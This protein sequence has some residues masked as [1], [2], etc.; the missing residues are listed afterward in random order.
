MSCDVADGEIEELECTDAGLSPIQPD[1]MP[2]QD[3]DTAQFTDAGT[4]P[5]E[6]LGSSHISQVDTSEAATLTDQIDTKDS[7]CS[8]IKPEESPISVT[9]KMRDEEILQRR[10]GSGD[11]KA[12]I[13]MLEEQAGK[14]PQ[15][16]RKKKEIVD[17]EDEMSSM[18]E[19]EVCRGST[20]TLAQLDDDEYRMES[21]VEHIV[22]ERVE[23]AIT[24]LNEKPKPV[25][26]THAKHVGRKIAE[27]QKIFSNEDV[28]TDEDS[29]TRSPIRLRHKHADEFASLP[30]HI[31]ETNRADEKIAAKFAENIV[32][33]ELLKVAGEFNRDT[34][35]RGTSEPTS[36]PTVAD[37]EVFKS[38]KDKTSMFEEL[39]SKSQESTPKKTKPHLKTTEE[40]RKPTK[41][42]ED[43]TAYLEAM[44]KNDK[45]SEIQAFKEKE[46]TEEEL[47]KCLAGIEELVVT[48]IP[49]VFEP[50]R[51]SEQEERS[52]SKPCAE[53]VCLKVCVDPSIPQPTHVIIK[54]AYELNEEP[55]SEVGDEPSEIDK[56]R[57]SLTEIEEQAICEV[58]KHITKLLPHIDHDNKHD[59]RDLEVSVQSG[60]Q[61][62]SNVLHISSTVSQILTDH[63]KIVET[64]SGDT[65]EAKEEPCV[66]QEVCALK[67]VK[68]DSY[69]S[70]KKEIIS[71]EMHEHV[72]ERQPLIPQTDIIRE[73]IVSHAK[74]VSTIAL[75]PEIAGD[76]KL[77]QVV[78]ANETLEEKTVNDVPSQLALHVL[79]PNKAKESLVEKPLKTHKS[80]AYDISVTEKASKI[81][82]LKKMDVK[83]PVTEQEAMKIM[84]EVLEASKQ[85]REDVKELKPDLTPTP[86]GQ[87]IS[88]LPTSAMDISEGLMKKIESQTLTA[89]DKKEM[90]NILYATLS[91]EKMTE[92]QAEKY[93]SETRETRIQRD[94][95]LENNEINHHV[96][97]KSEETTCLSAVSQAPARAI[98]PTRKVS[99]SRIATEIV[100]H[101]T[102]AKY[103]RELLPKEKERTQSVK[104]KIEMFQQALGNKEGSQ[105]IKRF[106]DNIKADEDIKQQGAKQLATEKAVEPIAIKGVVA[107][108]LAEKEKII[109]RVAQKESVP[110]VSTKRHETPDQPAEKVSRPDLLT[111][112]CQIE[113]TLDL[114]LKQHKTAKATDEEKLSE[115]TVIKEMAS[116]ESTSPSPDPCAVET[117]P[118]SGKI[119]SP[120]PSAGILA[121]SVEAEEPIAVKEE[122]SEV[123]GERSAERLP[124]GGVSQ[125]GED[126][127]PEPP[128]GTIN[129]PEGSTEPIAVTEQLPELASEIDN[130]SELP[131]K[132][133]VWQAEKEKSPELPAKAIAKPEVSPETLAEIEELPERAAE[134]DKSTEPPK[135]T[136]PQAEKDK[137]PESHAEAIAKLAESAEPNEVPK[138]LSELNAETIAVTEKLLKLDSEKGDLRE[139]P[140]KDTVPQVEKDKVSESSVETMAKS[141]VSTEH[142]AIKEEPPKLAHERDKS[143]EVLAEV[144][145]KPIEVREDLHGLRGEKYKSPQLPRIDTV[146]Q[147]EKDSIPEPPLEAMAKP[148]VSEGCIAVKE[149][150]PDLAAPK[151]KSPKPLPKDSVPQAE[152]YK[153]PG[154]PQEAMSKSEVSTQRVAVKE[155]TLELIA[156]KDKS[157]EPL[158]KDTAPQAEKDKAYE[159]PPETRAKS[160][161]QAE[162]IALKGQLSEPAAEKDK[163]TELPPKHTVSQAEKDKTPESPQ[164]TTTKSEDLSAPVAV[165]EV[166][167][168]KAAEKGKSPEPPRKDTV[169]QAE[170]DKTLGLPLEIMAKSE[171]SA[172]RIAVKEETLELVAPK[173]KSPE[174]LPKDTVPQAEMEKTPEPPPETTAKSEVSTEHIAVKE[175]TLELVSPNDKSP[176]PPRKVTV[177]HAEK[178]KT[179]EALPETMAKSD[180]SAARIAV[181]EGTLKLASPKD[182]S[183]GPLPEDTA[184][185]AEKDK[186]SE[187]LP[188]TRAKTEVPAEAAALKEQPPEPAAEKD[189][190]PEKP[191]KDTV[192]EKDGTHELPQEKTV[193]SD[194]SAVK[195]VL[196][197]KAADTE[198]SPEPPP[199]DTVQQAQKYKT[200]ESPSETIAKS[201]MSAEHIAVKRET[202][203][204]A[205]PKDKSPE[206]LPK[207]TT[208]QAEKDKTS[209][210]TPETRTKSE[211]PA[212]GISLKEQPPEPAAEKDKSRELP[213]KDTISQAEKDK[214]HE[215]A[216]ETTA[217]TEVSAAL[218]AVKEVLPEKAAEEVK[219]PNCHE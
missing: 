194:A 48:E 140:S 71:N 79:E 157:P 83:V 58:P 207:D 114:L 39:I 18:K 98:S 36:L 149:E 51:I 107:S 72:L 126:K 25:L 78:A 163:F 196:P 175:E 168:E 218:V 201:E 105:R 204:L 219:S 76:E 113:E 29:S 187:S 183:P 5:I 8:P 125:A 200:P 40:I 28:S 53:P 142:I 64:I 188:E 215:S 181:K 103:Q 14:S 212:E 56:P 192:A 136:V 90:E 144:S 112:E 214:T 49:S 177:P 170:K 213:S 88:M 15:H 55:K 89:K 2:I 139:A 162:G 63:I 84:S 174:P 118:R 46:Y 117:M 186:T 216:Q 182:I 12:K 87:L 95:T 176:E 75:P 138:R 104:D 1:E 54:R 132:G 180:I 159:S 133:T 109:G 130:L 198:K 129:K 195:E 20:E 47:S 209:E 37:P 13:R 208:S 101:E 178:D 33:P 41:E 111:D 77:A 156:P 120:Q 45:S 165:K 121:K 217:N 116:E 148:E 145:P 210:S 153:T 102:E 206:P 146:A 202:S 94:E 106:I 27:L 137:T 85:I 34:K 199:M 193:E 81:L 62:E 86:E 43:V 150:T 38:V 19:E 161:V 44:P 7:T 74:L 147:A 164:E 73:A 185:Q 108:G 141:E 11:V 167:P 9:D 22:K 21:I 91:S 52:P 205:A 92:L 119:K 82:E 110:H 16:F 68:A 65:L 96:K 203:E 3:D 155:E 6:F 166:L 50:S 23:E 169:L 190:S 35:V 154:S 60:E 134:K 143:P 66:K 67:P 93:P 26:G 30:A 197:E 32:E 127:Y 172:E 115:P 99:S 61:Y 189:R 151:Y 173:D 59:I 123:T 100:H 158:T 10:R 57:E 160:Q 122:L 211:V 69:P 124:K 31:C 97:C 80:L 135:I 184:H 42:R 131:L 152:K 70:L 179:P 24:E 171:I 191:P 4:S 17:S 128:A